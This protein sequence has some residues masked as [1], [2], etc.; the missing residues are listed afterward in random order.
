MTRKIATD[1]IVDYSD[2]EP[3]RLVQ[4]TLDLDTVQALRHGL[5]AASHYGELSAGAWEP[6]LVEAM[7]LSMFFRRVET[8]LEQPSL[9]TMEEFKATNPRLESWL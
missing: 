2:D 4:L 5:Y 7:D 8:E 1:F 6:V 3:K 9:F